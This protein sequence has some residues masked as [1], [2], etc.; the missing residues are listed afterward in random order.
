MRLAVCTLSAVLLSGC[1]WLG[2][3]GNSVNYGGAAVDCGN[4]AVAYGGQYGG[5]SCG[6][7]AGYALAGYGGGNGFGQA[8]YGQAGYGQAGYGQGAYGA[9]GYGA[10]GQAGIGLRGA[11]GG[12]GAGMG[13][14]SA[15]ANGYGMSTAGANGPSVSG[16]GANGYGTS[17]GG[18]GASAGTV[19]GGA[20]PYGAAAGGQ[21]INGQWV[22]GATSVAGG[23][24]Y[25]AAGN[26]TTVQGAPIYVQQPYPAYYPVGVAVGGLRGGSAALPFGVE[27]GIGTDIAIGGDIVDAKPAGPALTCCGGPGNLD[28]SATPAISYGDAYKNAVT[29]DMAA[30]YDVDPSTTLIGRI[31][32]SSADGQRLKIGTI[33][34][35]QINPAPNTTTEDLYAQWSDLEQ[36]TLEGGFRKYMGGWNNSMSGIRPYVGA[37]AGFTHNN[38]VTLA[39]ESATLM[40]VGAN[41]QQYIDAGWTPTASGVVGAE[42]QVGARTAIGVEAG[43]RWSDNLNTNFASEDRWSVPLKLRGRV[44]F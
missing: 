41:V 18:Y 42:M 40:P 12:A 20:A 13:A 26:V 11:Q 29:Y 27:F 25:G 28:V 1:S 38:A 37:M 3:G 44:S 36:V 43:I 23:Y 14:Y 33:D 15:G 2:Y 31:G 9:G 16:Y 4:A 10:Y 21:F 34:D 22:S 32:Y 30:T 19:L 35:R 6:A 17:A 8:G 7:G 5:G 39:Q 24:S